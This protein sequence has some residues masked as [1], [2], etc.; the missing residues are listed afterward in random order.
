MLHLRLKLFL[1]ASC[2]LFWFCLEKLEV[3]FLKA[4]LLPFVDGFFVPPGHW[5]FFVAFINLLFDI[6]F[7]AL[8]LQKLSEFLFVAGVKDPLVPDKAA[9]LGREQ[10]ELQCSG[11]FVRL[12]AVLEGEQNY[13]DAR[14]DP[15]CYPV[16]CLDESW[17]APLGGVRLPIFAQFTAYFRA[18]EEDKVQD[19]LCE[20][21]ACHNEKHRPAFIAEVIFA[22]EVGAIVLEGLE[23][24]DQWRTDAVHEAD[25]KAGPAEEVTLR[26]SGVALVFQLPY[27][28]LELRD[29]NVNARDDDVGLHCH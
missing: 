7:R 10:E 20:D 5:S 13:K 4:S 23:H 6:F 14:D 17:Q 27:R 18:K 11:R 19:G 3:F 21:N 25:L 24:G 1:F 16:V 28:L 26:F 2:S 22:C 8:L 15:V 12:E 29:E 9:Y